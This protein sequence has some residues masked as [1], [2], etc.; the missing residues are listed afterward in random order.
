MTF[1]KNSYS[2]NNMVLYV[3][4]VYILLF[5]PIN[6]VSISSIYT[7]RD[8]ESPVTLYSTMCGY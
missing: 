6:I 3:N 7:F 1:V 4:D 5:T 2:T 8:V